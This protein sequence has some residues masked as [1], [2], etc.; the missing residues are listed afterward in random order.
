MARTTLRIAYDG[1]ALADGVMEVRDLAPALLALGRL[2]EQANRVV[3]GEKLRLSVRVIAGF[4]AGSFEIDLDLLQ[5]WLR[6]VQDLLSGDGATALA[7]LI[8]FLGFG[9]GATLGLFQLIRHLRGRQPERVDRGD[10]ASRPGAP[11]RRTAIAAVAGRRSAAQLRLTSLRMA[12]RSPRAASG[13]ATAS[14]GLP[15]AAKP[16]RQAATAPSSIS[17]APNR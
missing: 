15:S 6:E 2:L 1:P 12:Y 5:S 13:G 11:Q 9:G 7:N 3:H 14:S 16:K 4:R 8:A 10:R 17:A